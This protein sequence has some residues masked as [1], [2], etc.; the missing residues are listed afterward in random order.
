MASALDRLIAVC[1]SLASDGRY[2]KKSRALAT[3][4]KAWAPTTQESNMGLLTATVTLTDAQI[5]SLPSQPVQVVTAPGAG[6][7]VQPLYA[8]AVLDVSAVYDMDAGARWQLFNG[9]RENTGFVV[10]ALSPSDVGKHLLQFPPFCGP[11]T[12]NN[13][14]YSG[15]YRR[16]EWF[17]DQPLNVADLYNGVPDYT[18]GDPANMLTVTVAYLVLDLP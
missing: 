16:V 10:P 7:Y 18:G 11:D 3:A 15:A 8:H 14:L 5:K 6:K 9:D 13:Y 12:Q 1:E 4:L 2:A 17:D